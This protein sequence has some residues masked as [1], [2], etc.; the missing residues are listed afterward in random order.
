MTKATATSGE[1]TKVAVVMVR[2]EQNRDSNEA[3]NIVRPSLPQRF[4]EEGAADLRWDKG[5]YLYFVVKC[6]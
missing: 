6:V 2:E 3:Y 1:E 4:R 5:E